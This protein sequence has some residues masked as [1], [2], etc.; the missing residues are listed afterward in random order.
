[1]LLYKKKW[2]ISL[3][4]CL[5]AQSLSCVWVFAAP[6][7]VDRQ[8]PM[9]TGFS[10]QEY[11]GGLS[12]P[13]PGDLPNPGMDPALA[14]RFSTT[15]PPGEPLPAWS[16]QNSETRTEYSYVHGNIEIYIN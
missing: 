8:A 15:E 7:A 6:W 2:N 1:M 10:R 9:S 3:S 14:G 4:P 13:P 11:W 16:L 5:H 12:F